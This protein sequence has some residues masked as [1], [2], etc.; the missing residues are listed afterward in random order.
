MVINGA[1]IPLTDIGVN[2]RVH[3]GD[4]IIEESAADASKP[5]YHC[6]KDV[7]EAKYA[8][9]EAKTTTK[10]GSKGSKDES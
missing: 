9:M 7:F 4:Y 1:Q 5:Y 10:S 6:P 8:E 3:I 2:N